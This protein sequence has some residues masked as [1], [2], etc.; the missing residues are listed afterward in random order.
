M[1]RELSSFHVPACL[2]GS[3]WSA[4]WLCG[5]GVGGE[6]LASPQ[7]CPGCAPGAQASLVWPG[8]EHFRSELNDWW[9][10]QQT[11][12][13]AGFRDSESPPPSPIAVT[14]PLLHAGR[15]LSPLHIWPC[16]VLI[17]SPQGT[18]LLSPL[19][20]Q[21]LRHWLNPFQTGMW[22]K[23]LNFSGFCLNL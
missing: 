8:C 9:E 2:L 7:G 5:S 20:G 12:E 19:M 4:E 18:G 22:I 10:M 21:M 23:P 11:K 17:A 1:S 13:D 14:K 6:G 16:P 15:V 3:L